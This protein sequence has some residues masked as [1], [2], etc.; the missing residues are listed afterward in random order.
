MKS[1]LTRSVARVAGMA[2]LAALGAVSM[3]AAAPASCV[4]P[5]PDPPPPPPEC[6]SDGDCAAGQHCSTSDGDCRT[7][8]PEGALCP[9]VCRGVCV[10][11]PAGCTSDADCRM[12]E[13]CDIGPCALAP[14]V[15]REDGTWDCPSCDGTC[16]PRPT[17]QCAAD[18]DCEAGK[19]CRIE[20]CAEAACPPGAD[21]SSPACWGC[22]GSCVPAGD[23]PPCDTFGTECPMGLACV[24]D[25]CTMCPD[26]TACLVAD[27]CWGHCEP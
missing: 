1:S 18:S 19:V 21:P 12:D 16:I 6:V 22:W 24:Y 23:P 15:V 10:D 27:G 20:V 14:C 13:M 9:E 3:G 7:G 2:A 5:D 4:S 26:E 25:E 17:D 8:C 11:D